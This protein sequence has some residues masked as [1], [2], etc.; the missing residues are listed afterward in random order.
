MVNDSTLKIIKIFTQEAK[1]KKRQFEFILFK[2][3]LFLLLIAIFMY[4][5]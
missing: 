2:L 5:T 1:N 4:I 3:L